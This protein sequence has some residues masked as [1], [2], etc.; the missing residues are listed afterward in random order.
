MST[1]LTNNIRPYVRKTYYI[2]KD[3]QKRFISGY[4]L[5]TL[6]GVV[7][8]NVLLY[9]RLIKGIDDAFYK[10]H[11][12]ITTTAEVVLSPLFFT[13]IVVVSASVAA[14]LITTVVNTW[15][16][17]SRL[18]CLSE[19]IYGLKNLDLTVQVKSC[20]GDQLTAEVADIFNKSV[21]HLNKKIGS[22]KSEITDLETTALSLS[23]DRVDDVE[24]LLMKVKSIED[25]LS[26]FKLS[27]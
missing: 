9:T 4:I 23:K 7:I 15:K 11:I 13:S 22:I 12:G 14:I 10:A 17:G 20:H 5:L 2:K 24:Q 19:G 6:L 16:V 27:Q 21:K 1:V 3:F 18:H 25:H 8:A 26:A